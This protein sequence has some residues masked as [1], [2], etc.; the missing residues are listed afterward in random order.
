MN[1]TEIDGAPPKLTL[2]TIGQFKKLIK[3]G[4]VEKQEE[5]EFLKLKRQAL[6]KQVLFGGALFYYAGLLFNNPVPDFRI[7]LG[8]L[9]MFFAANMSAYSFFASPYIAFVDKLKHKY[10]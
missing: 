1:S 2:L 8:R 10:A 5:A 4:R 7:R 9:L 3:Q 6:C